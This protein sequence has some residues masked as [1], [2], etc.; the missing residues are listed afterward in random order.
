MI[1]GALGLYVPRTRHNSDLILASDSV[2]PSWLS[3]NQFPGQNVQFSQK[4]PV[5]AAHNDLLESW[6]VEMLL[7]NFYFVNQSGRTL[8][9][10]VDLRAN[11]GDDERGTVFVLDTGKYL[12]VFAK[13]FLRVLILL[14]LHEGASTSEFPPAAA[15]TIRDAFFLA[16]RNKNLEK[17]FDFAVPEDHYEDDV[18]IDFV[19][20]GETHTQVTISGP[21]MPFIYQK[22]DPE[23][24]ALIAHGRGE[25]YILGAVSHQFVTPC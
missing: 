8:W 19:F 18:V 3:I 20:R 2:D 6:S 11:P 15:D 25:P 23:S 12:S 24:G 4:I 10:T 5:V 16:D 1:H 14:W 9:G 13:G 7:M 22:T 17:R 21:A